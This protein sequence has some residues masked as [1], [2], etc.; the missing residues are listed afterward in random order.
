[1]E[2][3]PQ[4]SSNKWLVWLGIGCGGVVVVV[5]V[6]VIGGYFFVRNMA[7][8]FR[9]SQGLMES[10]TAKYGRIEDYCP[11]ADGTVPAAR[12]EVFLA[13]R[14]AMS[15]AR[16]TL[17]ESFR[18]VLK[19]RDEEGRPSRN[20]L[21]AVRLG[22]GVVTPISAF[23][24]A[25]AE[26]LIDKGMGPGEYSYI[27]VIAY[28]SWLKK[29]P[30]DGVGLEVM[31]ERPGTPAR[32]REEALEVSRDITLRRI[33]R[34]VLPLLENQLAK[35]RAGAAA[36]AG[37]GGDKWAEALAAEIKA[38]AADRARIP[39]QDGVPEVIDRSLRPFRERLEAAYVPVVNVFELAFERR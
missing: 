7:R 18:E 30:T 39:W 14:A 35:R 1:M 32:D 37:K 25:R 16:Q 2:M 8:G 29:P 23:F 10:L 21:S 5:V 3:L 34:L 27:Y 36:G 38:L 19:A 31:G 17:A 22:L 26:S 33:N 6:L 12:I 4:K 13:A 11:D 15:P 20:I 24:K 9:D 28:Y